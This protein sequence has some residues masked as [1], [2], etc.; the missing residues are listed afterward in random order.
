[1]WEGIGGGV[2]ALV[3]DRALPGRTAA[4]AGGEGHCFEEEPNLD[5]GAHFEPARHLQ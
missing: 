1:M 5:Y 2:G 4:D 3:G